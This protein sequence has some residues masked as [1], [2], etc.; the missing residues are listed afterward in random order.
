MGH[1]SETEHR[2]ALFVAALIATAFVAISMPEGGQGSVVRA[3]ATAAL[4]GAI[5]LGLVFGA[6]PRTTIAKPALVA[7]SALGGLALLTGASML[8]GSDD[9]RTFQ[10]F[11]RVLSY[12][13]LF[14]CTVLAT[15]HGSART[16]LHGLGAGL[17]LVS[18]IAL[19]SRLI[20]ELFPVSEIHQQRPDTISRLAYPLDYWN[21]DGLV[22][23][24][25]I[26]LMA[27][28]SVTAERRWT[29]ALGI[30]L[31]PPLALTLFFTSSRGSM[32][33]LAL[34]L[35][36]LLGVDRRRLAIT[37]GLILGGLG[38]L[39]PLGVAL[40]SPALVDG[41]VRS[42]PG[43]GQAHMA[44][45]VL[46][47]AAAVVGGARAF[48]DTWMQRLAVRKPPPWARRATLVGVG[49]LVLAVL[50]LGKPVQRFEQFCA[51][52]TAEALNVSP[53]VHLF[54][55]SG[56]G[57]CQFW[58]TAIGAFESA[59]LT[60]IGAGGYQGW[61]GANGTLPLYIQNAHSLPLETLG[62][63]GIGGFALLVAFLLTP[64]VA[65]LRRLQDQIR[66]PS[67]APAMAVL[68]M[69]LLASSIDWMWELPAALVPAVIAAGLLVGPALSPAP[70]SGRARFG[71]GVLAM[72][73][74]WV[75]ILSSA[76]SLFTEYKIQQ[77]KNAFDANDAPG[78]ILNAQQARALQPWAAE[79][80]LQEMFA[81]EKAGNIPAALAAAD[82]A[83]ARAPRDWA[84]WLNKGRILAGQRD[85]PGALAAGYTSV[86][87]RPDLRL[88]PD[89]SLPPETQVA[90]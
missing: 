86:F 35:A 16:W 22:A 89:V 77:S 83:I 32:V 85:Q 90:P 65:G 33:A 50:V 3:I 87:L 84:L 5:I 44:L 42:G 75:A 40:A 56:G 17:V 27:W 53:G 80:R 2:A 69:G 55:D 21:G 43:L 19:L 78:A 37:A 59:P 15:R 49:V 38:T 63:L 79:P 4:W 60:G 73:M 30:G 7:G 72:M 45:V 34:G 62:D 10:E 82:Q 74:G 24:M 29:R 58:R 20:P 51:P 14:L 11:I 46:I 28:L 36:V 52:P 9:G 31:L 8:W 41:V 68:A 12:L 6:W 13:G 26:V 64:L 54:N 39:I 47:A 70:A 88:R 81:Q 1:P 23:A 66:D 57:R 71:F 61:W 48:L 67:L 76:A 18:L 25:A